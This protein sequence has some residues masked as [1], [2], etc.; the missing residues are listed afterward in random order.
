[1]FANL[2]RLTYASFL[3]TV[4]MAEM[5]ARTT[6]IWASA[7]ADMIRR[8]G[9]T[10]EDALPAIAPPSRTELTAPEAREDAGVDLV[11]RAVEKTEAQAT[12]STTNL[13]DAV[14]AATADAAETAT[15]PASRVAEAPTKPK[16]FTT[17]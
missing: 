8:D 14:G 1:M 5:T 16:P 15:T 3:P 10:D 13:L 2:Q 9:T 4:Y 11:A 17:N 7:M 12:E 6:S